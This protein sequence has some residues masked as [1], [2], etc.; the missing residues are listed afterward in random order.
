VNGTHNLLVS[1]DDVNLLDKKLNI[2][3]ILIQTSKQAGLEVRAD[4]G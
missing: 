4:K 3:N 2:K 1:T